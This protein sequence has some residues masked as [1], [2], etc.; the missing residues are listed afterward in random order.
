[1][2]LFTPKWR[3][4]DPQ[5]RMAWINKVKPNNPRKQKKLVQIAI[6]DPEESVSLLALEKIMD[7]ELLGEISYS[8]DYINVRKAAVRK[9][10][11]EEELKYLLEMNDF[12]DNDCLSI[13]IELL[14]DNKK[15]IQIAQNNAYHEVRLA[16]TKKLT[17]IDVLNSI[18]ILDENDEVVAAANERIEALMPKPKLSSFLPLIRRS[19][20]CGEAGFSIGVRN[21][22]K[23]RMGKSELKSILISNFHF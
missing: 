18:T 13:A 11:D 6:A 20:P 7:N 3:H 23:E 8:S 14:N 10:T 5:V 22:R 1:M 16:A 17:D 15:L 12:I 9:I 19:R 4:K 2:G 21:W